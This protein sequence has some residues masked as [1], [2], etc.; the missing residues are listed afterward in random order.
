M[1]E[2]KLIHMVVAKHILRYVRGTI[3]YGLT[4]TSSGGVLL[5]GYIDLVWMG[6]TVDQKST[7]GYC[8]SLGSVMISWFSRKQD[9]LAKSTAKAEYIAGSIASREAV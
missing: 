7:F 3:A 9:S 6:S 5:H 1:C 8:F 2:P 4:Y